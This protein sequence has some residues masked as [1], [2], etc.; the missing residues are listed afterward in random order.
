MRRPDALVR[1]LAL[2]VVAATSAAAAHADSA[3]PVWS[4]HRPGGGTVYLA[5]SVH[6]L[7]TARSRLPPAFDAAWRDAERIVMELDMDDLDP[8]AAAAFLAANA[9]IEG[10][11]NLR[12]LL[13][14]ERFV[15]VD[16]QARALGLPL[17]SVAQLEPW[18]VALA[19]TQLQLVKLGLDPQQGVEQQLTARARAEGKPIAG[20]E[21]IDEQ[22]GI[23]DGLSYTDQA[24]FLELTAAE[25]DSISA[26]LDG[27]LAAWRRADTAALERLLLVEYERLPTLYRPLVTDRNRRWL[28][29]I[30]ALLARPDDTLVVVGALHLVGPDGLLALLRE[31]GLVPSPVGAVSSLRQP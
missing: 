10:D 11:G 26:E 4:I 20:L 27:I 13:G 19:L 24:R 12:T 8:A 16:A 28:P 25:S 1:T 21:S 18:A 17:D 7:D 31:R 6:V 2:F 3:G 5:G 23:L 9:T 29:Q 22:L 14:A 15:R 30:E